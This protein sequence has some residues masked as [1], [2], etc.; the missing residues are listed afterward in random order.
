MAEQ[1][2]ANKAPIAIQHALPTSTVKPSPKPSNPAFRMMGIPNLRF[3]LPSRNWLIFL[4]ITGSFT[5]AL[6]YDRY[7]KRKAQ[8]RW[9]QV[10]SHLAEEPLPPDQ[11]P[12]TVAIFLAAPPGDGLRAAREHFHE[13]IKPILVAGALDWEVI[14][15]RREGE[16]R[17]GLASKIRRIR[18]RNGE[19]SADQDVEESVEDRL[20]DF[21]R[22]A[23]IKIWDGVQGDLIL[24]RHTWKEYVRGIHE[25]WLGP[26]DPPAAPEPSFP[27]PTT[28]LEPSSVPMTSSSQPLAPSD[29]LAHPTP[30]EAPQNSNSTESDILPQPEPPAQEPEK[31][32][33]KQSPKISPTPPY[34]I[35]TVY[36]TSSLS[37]ESPPALPPTTVL[38]FPHLLGFLNTPIRIYRFLNRR[39]LADETGRSVATMVLASNTRTFDTGHEFVTSVDPNDGS[40]SSADPTAEVVEASVAWEQ[41]KLLVDEEAEWHKSVWTPNPDDAPERERPWQ[42]K[43]S[44]DERIGTRM[45][46][47]DLGKQEEEERLRDAE[48]AILAE[49]RERKGRLRVVM[50]W[51]GLR[52]EGGRKGWEMGLV[53]G[54]D[55]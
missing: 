31:P 19:H 41:E 53:G 32:P 1:P 46:V 55:E 18:R 28:L 21:R 44:I 6:L 12:R 29:S 33:D 25:G 9:C 35:P 49:D 34:I 4:S 38:P 26:L 17:A 27:D 45:R 54:E 50:E 5:T 43:M 52:R 24:G 42:E 2:V 51:L 37:P 13:Y 3:R 39:H 15:G 7:H 11:I 10:V 36:T 16:V 14:E 20:E 40:P 47:F 48:M 23:R 22:G 8:R 30:D